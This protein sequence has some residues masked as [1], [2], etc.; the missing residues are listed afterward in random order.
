MSRFGVGIARLLFGA[1]ALVAVAAAPGCD[2]LKGSD[3]TMR[4]SPFISG[5]SVSPSAVLC[6]R[7][8]VISFRYDDPQSDISLLRLTFKHEG[9][10]LQVQDQAL[11]DPS[12]VDLSVSGR[13]SYGYT[14]G[15][16]RPGGR[17]AVTV[18]L[19]DQRGHTSNTATTSLTLNSFGTP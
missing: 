3:T 18:Q 10:D 7:Q 4:V 13:A 9:D 5:L 14:L 2:W 6:G 16:D 19:E 11:W 15:C 17:W 1:A 12:T 8:F